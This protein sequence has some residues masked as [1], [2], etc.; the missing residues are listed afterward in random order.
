LFDRYRDHRIPPA[1][2][3]RTHHVSTKRLND[4]F[5]RR[6]TITLKDESSDNVKC[7]IWSNRGGL[8]F[9]YVS[10][11]AARFGACISQSGCLVGCRWWVDSLRHRD[12]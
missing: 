5:L 10:S 11:D 3:P 12:R 1:N 4:L 7:S 2:L 6:E 8:Q 9:M